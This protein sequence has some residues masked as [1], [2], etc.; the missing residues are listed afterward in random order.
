MMSAKNYYIVLGVSR[1]ADTKKIKKAYR[2]IAKQY[3]PDVSESEANTSRFLEIKEAYETLGDEE[4]RKRYDKTLSEQGSPLRIT[5]VPDLV[6]TRRAYFDEM[7]EF[8]SGADEFFSGLLPGLFER[9]GL[10]RAEKELY[11]EAILSPTEAMKGGLIPV[12]VPVVESCPRCTKTGLWDNFICPVCSGYGRVK[13]ERQFS[14]SIP[15][16]VQH[17]TEI[18]LSMEDIGLKDIHLNIMVFIDAGLDHEEW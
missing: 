17:G 7:D 8:F 13:G 9:T 3:H 2:T 15:P 5:R 14:V 6:D 12:T 11:F 10:R 4:K 18:R 16:R 1:A